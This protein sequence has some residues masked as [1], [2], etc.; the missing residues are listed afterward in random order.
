MSDEERRLYLAEIQSRADSGF[1][2]PYD[3]MVHG[4]VRGMMPLMPVVQLQKSTP[5]RP[6]MDFKELNELLTSE[7]RRGV[8]SCTEALRQWRRMGPKCKLVDIRKAYLQIRL[9][10]SLRSFQCL[11]VNGTMYVMTRMAFGLSIARN[12]LD[13]IVEYVLRSTFPDDSSWSNYVDDILVDDDR[14]DA[15]LVAS[16]LAGFALPVKEPVH[17]DGSSV[18]GLS[19]WSKDSAL[20]CGRGKPVP[21]LPRRLTKRTV[22]QWCGSLV[23]HYPVAGWLR[24]ASSYLRRLCSACGKWDEALPADAAEVARLLWEHL[25]SDDPVGGVWCV[26]EGSW[27]LYT[28]ASDL[29]RGSVLECLSVGAR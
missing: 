7:P 17:L 22:F 16:S 2:E 9:D 18:L 15:S 4:P 12:V 25:R 20:V 1:I 19:V 21:D 28:D 29:A 11:S 24:V 5:V 3:A 14:S 13:S 8:K 6:V 27:L 10:K 26:P 23:G